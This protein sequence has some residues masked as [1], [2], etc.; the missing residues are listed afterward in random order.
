MQIVLHGDRRAGGGCAPVTGERDGSPEFDML[1][2]RGQVRSGVGNFGYW[3]DLLAD[4]YEQKTGMRFYP[5][6]LNL[7][8]PEEYSLPNTVIRLEAHEYDGRSRSASSPA[9]SSIA[10]PFSCAP[11]KTRAVRDITRATSSKSRPT[12]GCGTPTG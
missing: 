7:E 4:L 12:S 11:I 5:G 1:R 6:T 3:I 10:P 9:A 2:L 8:L